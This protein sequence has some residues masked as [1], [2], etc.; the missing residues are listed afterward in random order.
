MPT[1]HQSHLS[2]ITSDWPVAIVPFPNERNW[3]FI[4]KLHCQYSFCDPMNVQY[5]YCSQMATR[6]FNFWHSQIRTRHGYMVQSHE[7]IF[8]T[9]YTTT[10]NRASA[11]MKYKGGTWL[12]S[13]FQ[14]Y[15]CTISYMRIHRWTFANWYSNEKNVYW[16]FKSYGVV[17]E[18]RQECSVP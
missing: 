11:N 3:I 12:W 17:R 2:V 10:M 9:S 8:N 15:S 16:L 18:S 7:L 1:Q 5:I 6:L 13:I 4:R 14:L